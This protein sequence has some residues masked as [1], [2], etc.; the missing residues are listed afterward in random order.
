MS[1]TKRRSNGRSF[2]MGGCGIALR[3][4][5]AI[6]VCVA[7]VSTIAGTNELLIISGIIMSNR[8]IV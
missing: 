2:L 5:R 7:L 8:L 4:D 1:I 6:K 3:S